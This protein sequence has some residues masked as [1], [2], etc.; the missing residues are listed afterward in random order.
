M[1]ACQILTVHTF[2]KVSAQHWETS[3]FK[4]REEEIFCDLDLL[5]NINKIGLRVAFKIA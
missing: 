5:A 2:P 4:W 1:T 3:C